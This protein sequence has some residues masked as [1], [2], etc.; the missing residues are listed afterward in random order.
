MMNLI[1][2]NKIQN[3]IKLQK[4]DAK[5]NKNYNLN[6]STKTYLL[7]DRFER[8]KINFGARMEEREHIKL[9]NSKLL[10]ILSYHIDEPTYEAERLESDKE[11]PFV[12]FRRFFDSD[13][14]L[15]KE[16]QED[17]KENI[18]VIKV[19]DSNGKIKAWLT[20]GFSAINKCIC[21]ANHITNEN[22]K[23]IT[24]KYQ[25]ALDDFEIS[26]L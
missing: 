16:I 15:R 1:N 6:V 25:I 20:T 21:V 9:R 7:P 8:S 10:E 26:A 18:E 2:F 17:S 14:K 23:T 4:L 5:S 11:V 3:Q 19:Y 22:G 12:Y 13:G 24:N